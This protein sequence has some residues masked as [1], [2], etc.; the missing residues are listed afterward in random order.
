MAQAGHLLK[1][2][3]VFNWPNDFIP[4]GVLILVLLLG[5]CSVS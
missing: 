3:D 5:F 4:C 2:A 1:S